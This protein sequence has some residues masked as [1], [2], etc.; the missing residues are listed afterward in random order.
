MAYACLGFSKAFA[1]LRQESLYAMNRL[2]QIVDIG[3][4]TTRK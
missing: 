3:K 1:I 4:N 2:G